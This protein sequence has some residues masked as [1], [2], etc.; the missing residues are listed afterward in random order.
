MFAESPSS[1]QDSHVRFPVPPRLYGR[2]AHLA[3]L[4]QGL[5][6]VAQ[7]GQPE[8]I[9]VR[10]YSGIGKSSLVN[11]LGRPV[12]QRR[13]FF[14]SGKCDQFQREIPYTPLAKALRGLTYQ[15]MASPEPERTRWR[16]RLHEAWGD[17]G[18]V[19]VDVVPPL[20]FLVGRQ[21]PVPE[22]PPAE[23]Q[24]RFNRLFLKFLGVFATPERPL[25]VFLDDLQWV[26]LASLRVLR[27]LL[28]RPD[29]LP[30]L[31]VGA[32]RDNEIGPSHALAEALA[33]MRQADA[34]V[35]DLH[36]PPLGLE[37]VQRLVS[38]ALPG[39]TEPISGPLAALIHEKTGGN[40][41]FLLQFMWTLA[42]D[43]LLSR[44][45]EGA[46][47]W[48]AEAIRA[49]DYS[50]N[51]V[52]FMVSRLRQLPTPLQ[53]LLQLAACVGNSFPLQL[54]VII[55]GLEPREVQPAL[56]QALQEGMLVRGGPE[57]YR[58][59]HD[60]IQQAA[61]A[62]IPEPERKAVHL[63]IGRI[64]LA[65]LPAEALREQIFEV[66][67][68]L[69]AG[70]ELIDDPQERHRVARLNAEAGRKASASTAFRSA[71]AYF[72]LAFGLIPGDPWRTDRKL[73]FKLQLDRASSEFMSGNAAG[74]RRMVEE[75]LR[76]A[77]TPR[78]MAAVYRLKSDVH[79][80]ANEIQQALSCLLEALDKLGMPLPPHPTWEEVL[81]AHKEVRALLVGRSIESLVE[82]PLM[83]DPHTTAIMSVLAALFT[84]AIFTD[85]NLLTLHLC[86]MVSIS[87]RHGNTEA[88][89]HGYAWY[90]MV[91]GPI[92]K[93]YH[94]GYDFG[95]LACDLVERH[96]FSG[97]RAKALYSLEMIHYWTGPLSLSLELVRTAFHHALQ[98]GDFQVACYAS[99]HIV[100]DRLA[101]GHPLEEVYTESVERLSFARTSGYRA[102]EDVIHFTQRH[103]Q[104]LRGL[105]RSFDTLSGDGF[106]EEAFEVG[107]TPQ[108]M[109]TMRCWYWLIKLRSRFLCGAY[110]QAL[111]AADKAAELTW[112][113]LGHIQLLDF[114]LYRALTL[115]ACYPAAMPEVRPRYLEELRRHHQQLVEWAGLCA[116][117][118]LAA[119]QLVAA[120]LARIAGGMEEALRAYEEA[121]RAAR[122]H[123]FIQYEALACELAAGFWRERRVPTV[124]DTYARQARDA[125]L[126]WGAHGKVRQLEAQWSHLVSFSAPEASPSS[127]RPPPRDALALV[128]ALSGELVLERL[129]PALTRMALESAEAQ[130]GALLLPLHKTLSVAA[131]LDAAVPG[132]SERVS[133]SD[134]PWELLSYVSRTREHVLINDT[135]Q[136]HVFSF[137][138]YLARGQ[139]RAVLCLPV[140]QGEQLRGVLY[141]ENHR[142]PHTFTSERMALLGVL[143]AQAACSIEN[144][145]LY[146]SAQRAEEALRHANAE[147]EQRLEGR[148]WELKQAE[149]RLQDASRTSDLPEFAAS[150]LHNVGNVLNSAVVNLHLLRKKVDTSRLGRLKQLTEL[151]EEHRG[152]LG[153]FL[154]KDPHGTHVMTYLFELA[155]ELLREQG[156]LRESMDKLSKHVDHIRAILRIQ[157][158]YV[159]GTLLPEECEL[160][161][162]IEDALSIQLP[163]LQRHNITVTRELSSLPKVRVDKHRVL[164]ILINLITNARYAM[165]GLPGEQRTLRVRLEAQGNT[166]RIQVV[167]TGR[168]IA[169]EHRDKLFSQGFTTRA[170]GQ[171]LGLHSSAAAA[172]TLGGRLTLESDGPGM[173]ATATLELPLA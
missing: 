92:F 91:L 13:G 153:A 41:F 64:Q 5:E 97:A 171:G 123:G 78:D 87:L 71:A 142:G 124:A 93:R 29:A 148:T 36:L 131:S 6:R 3:T 77:V 15:L 128:Q 63:R 28:T 146:A 118:F 126:R 35:L 80:A 134:L 106:D 155:D 14:L 39:A 37:H 10:G 42:Q 168:G 114:H 105:S 65:S 94:E 18:Q 34:R 4:L 100:T 69:N 109:S 17:Q 122:A 20:E 99:N 163:A 150:V 25:V 19:L 130:R 49:K 22:L 113:S 53:H 136:P 32:C 8:F 12:A 11:E 16:E 144:A 141:L 44:T 152:N 129:A 149:A 147:L 68:Q 166:A 74:I 33:E 75:L 115:A 117:N 116:Q 73:A 132:C 101:L 90:G 82:L 79:L 58:F 54:L 151:L 45:P 169:L 1:S 70:A 81:A 26:D 173:G 139:A 67:A 103:V 156:G 157:Q 31:L 89:V 133:E 125:Y 88:S 85:A 57:Q 143:A 47:R 145:H 43:G 86:R 30:L 170:G 159:R 7:R 62:L 38:D 104:Q 24:H 102:V 76:R 138:P 60:R 46:W 9:L 167:D 61:Y 110:T 95:V 72:Q 84:P 23:A 140:V 40:P 135:S 165:E 56:E 98:S 162:L 96:R 137:D 27:Y 59:L 66:V 21:P 121:I 52:D 164:Q 107:L 161:Q 48:E 51:V 111:E 119:E 154:E 120:E 112:S 55:S 2:E 50:D 127:E 108:H 172:K 160:V 83:T 158:N